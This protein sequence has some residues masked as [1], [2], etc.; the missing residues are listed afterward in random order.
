M[1]SKK[2]LEAIVKKARKKKK[3]SFSLLASTMS[4]GRKDKG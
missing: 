1:P 2:E 4:P 3:E